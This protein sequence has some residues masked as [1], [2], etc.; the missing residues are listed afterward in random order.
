MSQELQKKTAATDL[1]SLARLFGPAPVLSTEDPKAY[2]E[3][4]RRLME[5]FRPHDF[6]E[7]MLV[8]DVANAS[9]EM[10]RLKRHKP[11]A[12]ERKFRQPLEFQANR[13][14]ESALN[15]AKW[16]ARKGEPP[17]HP[18]DVLES[19]VKDV[20]AIM[21]RPVEELDHARALEAAMPYYEWLSK[22]YMAAMATRNE[23]LRQLGRYREGLGHLLRRVSDEIVDAEFTDAEPHPK[24]IAAADSRLERENGGQQVPQLS[25]PDA[26]RHCI[27]ERE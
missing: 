5:C 22:R 14:K 18:E 26:Q 20:D 12:I 23:A 6:M 19:V 27:S 17:V 8:D 13:V 11:L 4:M 1:T 10:R 9:W 15:K 7:Q 21:N 25:D 16:A 3:I 24:Q 2:E